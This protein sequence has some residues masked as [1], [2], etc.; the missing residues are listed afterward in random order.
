MTHEYKL[1]KFADHL[2]RSRPQILGH[3]WNLRG[4]RC[5][6][7]HTDQIQNHGKIGFKNHRHIIDLDRI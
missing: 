7:I 5:I 3:D 1:F 6:P 4:R 2:L